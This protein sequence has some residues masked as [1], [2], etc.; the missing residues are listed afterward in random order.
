MANTQLAVE[1]VITPTA[2]AGGATG[3]VEM[4][5]FNTQ[6]KAAR[7]W[8]HGGQDKLQADTAACVPSAMACKRRWI[9]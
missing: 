4:Q 9:G 3:L 1:H 7:N 8:F 2:N 6:L 5:Q